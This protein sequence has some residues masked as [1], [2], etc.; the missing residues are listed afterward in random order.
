MY[1]HM[2]SR[3]IL[4]NNC[5]RHAVE[6]NISLLVIYYTIKKT[7]MKFKKTQSTYW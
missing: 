7:Y 6:G 2:N 1:H 3:E 4:G 5:T